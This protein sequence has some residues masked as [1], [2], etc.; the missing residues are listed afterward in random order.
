MYKDMKDFAN[1]YGNLS[2]SLINSMGN[3][4]PLEYPQLMPEKEEPEEKIDPREYADI[5]GGVLNSG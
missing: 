2:V 5:S 1:I 4:P 3:A